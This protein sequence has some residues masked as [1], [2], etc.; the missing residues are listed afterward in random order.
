[1]F[2]TMD[3]LKQ[4][5]TEVIKCEPL[6]KKASENCLDILNVQYHLVEEGMEKCRVNT[7]VINLLLIDKSISIHNW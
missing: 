6:L 4:V 3:V 2:Q 7:K 1:M 5:P